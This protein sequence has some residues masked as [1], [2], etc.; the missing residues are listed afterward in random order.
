MHKVMFDIPSFPES[1]HPLTIS[2]FE[3]LVLLIIISHFSGLSDS[4]KIALEFCEPDFAT[5][6]PRPNCFATATDSPAP[7]SWPLTAHLATMWVK[8]LSESSH[9]SVTAIRWVLILCS[10]KMCSQG[11]RRLGR[12]GNHPHP[13]PRLRMNGAILPAPPCAFM[14]CTWKTL[15]IRS[16]KNRS[17]GRAT[18]FNCCHSALISLAFFI[19]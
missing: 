3:L 8:G 5:T 17:R 14:A 6:T 10:T 13:V 1:M 9:N 11:D 18:F 15:P 2:T 12:A 16:K 19:S 4:Y 7:H